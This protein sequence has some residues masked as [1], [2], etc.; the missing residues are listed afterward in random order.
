MIVCITFQNNFKIWY[1]FDKFLKYEVNITYN[2]DFNKF[3]K[4]GTSN[5]I[6]LVYV[7]FSY[8]N[9]SKVSNETPIDSY[10]YAMVVIEFLYSK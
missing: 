4:V 6:S 1:S 9:Y 2:G 8:K 7:T 10:N 5:V 3:S